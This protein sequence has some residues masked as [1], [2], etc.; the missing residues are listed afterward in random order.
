MPRMKILST[1]EQ[2]T[3]DTPPLFNSAQ[4]KQYFDAS[5]QI[6]QIANGLRTP[7]NRLYFLLSRDYFKATKR[8]FPARTF[9]SRDIEYVASRDGLAFVELAL[10]QAEKQEQETAEG[11][12]RLIK[13]CITCWNYLYLSQK[14]T[15][16]K[17]EEKRQIL[18]H[19][20]ANGSVVS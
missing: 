16:A 8:F 20:I 13:N 15:E 5:L 11:C 3:F 7:I 6:Q 17:E 19:A 1:I 14:L 18:L 12:K 10:S 4:R 2:E 9:H